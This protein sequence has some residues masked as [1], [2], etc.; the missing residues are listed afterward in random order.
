EARSLFA[1]APGDV[2]VIAD[3]GAGSKGG[4]QPSM[5]AGTGTPSDSVSGDA[6]AEAAAGGNSASK[7]STGSGSGA[8]G[9]YG[10]GKGSGLNPA[11]EGIGSGRGTTTGGGAG[12]GVGVTLGSGKGAGSAAGSGGFPGITISGGRY[13]NGDPAGMHSTLTPHKQTS[14]SMTITS[15]ASSGGGL[16][17]FGVF[18]DEKIYTVYLDMRAN[19]EDH[20]ASWILQYAVVQPTTG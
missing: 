14:Y 2:T 16:A 20:T 6:V 15:T 7:N 8:G 18:H 9:R 19:E 11:G 1:V 4:G 3:P 5:A 13:G 12:T 10:S 17:D